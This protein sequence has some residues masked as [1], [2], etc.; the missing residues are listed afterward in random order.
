[1]MEK[2]GGTGDCF[3]EYEKSRKKCRCHCRAFVPEFLE[4]SSKTADDKFLL[5]K[6]IEK[7]FSDRH[8][9]KW[10]PLYSR[11]TFSDRPL[12]HLLL[13]IF[14]RNYAEYYD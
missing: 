10:I 14:K 11:V 8:P 3:S 2:Y 13:V 4:M 6:K 9:D 1:M 7:V 12:R 5:Q